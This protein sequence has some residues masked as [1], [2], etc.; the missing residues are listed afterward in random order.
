[1]PITTKSRRKVTVARWAGSQHPTV[2]SITRMMREEGL[3]P[4]EWDNLPNY[5]YAVRSHNYNKVLYVL[6]G[7]LEITLPDTNE[8]VR[9]KVGD[10]INIPAGVRH[11]TILGHTGARC[12]EASARR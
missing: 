10:R 4:Y 3:R 12:V 8:R 6:A 9:L 2:S 5:R 1:M 7:S 11:G